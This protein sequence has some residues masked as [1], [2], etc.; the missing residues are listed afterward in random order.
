MSDSA[1]TI[2]FATRNGEHVLPR[3]LEAYCG[4]EAP[5]QAW[6]MVVVDNGS[7]DLTPAILK[8]FKKRLPLEIA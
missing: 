8:S 3:T 7:D 6:K 4:L 1:L 2:L 5:S